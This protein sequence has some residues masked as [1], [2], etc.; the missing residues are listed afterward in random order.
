MTSTSATIENMSARAVG[1]GSRRSGRRVVAVAVVTA[2]VV[3]SIGGIAGCPGDADLCD[4]TIWE[5]GVQNPDYIKDCTYCGGCAY[6]R[7][8]PTPAEP[9]GLCTSA[10]VRV[11]CDA[12]ERERDAG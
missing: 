10:D 1:R 9:D 6:C 4:P 5:D 3:G 2:L 7:S 11:L 12:C 8:R